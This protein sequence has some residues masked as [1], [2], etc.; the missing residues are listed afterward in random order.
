[1]KK[2]LAAYLFQEREWVDFFVVDEPFVPGAEVEPVSLVRE[3]EV[4]IVNPSNFRGRDHLLAFAKLEELAVRAWQWLR[5]PCVLARNE[6]DESFKGLDIRGYAYAVVI[7]VGVHCQDING[8]ITGV[9]G[10]GNGVPD[11]DQ[12]VE[13]VELCQALV[14]DIPQL[15]AWL[16]AF[17]PPPEPSAFSLVQGTE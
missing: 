15:L 16:W 14:E 4:H 12:V 10:W 9:P 13:V 11:P 1:M 3:L 17:S 6:S 7:C 8:L 5:K 2:K